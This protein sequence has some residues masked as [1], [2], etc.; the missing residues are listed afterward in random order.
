MELLQ[1]QLGYHFKDPKHLALALTHCSCGPVNN[2]RLEFLGDSVL[3]VV[4]ADLAYVTGH[5]LSEG[6]LTRLRSSMVRAAT[7]ADLARQMSLHTKLQFVVGFGQRPVESMDVLSDTLEA[8]FGAVYLDGGFAVAKDVISRHLIRLLVAGKIT[9]GRDAKST[10]QEVMQGRAE[11]VP[12]YS[13]A[14]QHD[15]FR[16]AQGGVTVRCAIR[17]GAIHA[18]ATAGNKKLAGLEAARKVLAILRKRKEI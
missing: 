1:Q 12:V 13:L 4:A 2:E 8:V 14:P 15:T 18:D 16:A 6:E 17:N 7:L 3:N 10:L 11:A 5:D 9:M